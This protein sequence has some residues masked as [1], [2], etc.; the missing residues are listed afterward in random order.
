[1]K[2]EFKWL[3]LVYAVAVTL[4]VTLVFIPC[5][6]GDVKPGFYL[7]LF[8][9]FFY[10]AI[11]SIIIVAIIRTKWFEMPFGKC[12]ECSAF[13]CSSFTVGILALP[14]ALCRSPREDPHIDLLSAI[15]SFFGH[16]IL[17]NTTGFFFYRLY[18]VK[19]NNSWWIWMS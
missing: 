5:I 11:L 2:N 14:I 19:Q 16:F 13:W 18:V 15:L 17:I 3:T 4:A 9:F 6:L 1:M 8:C 10:I 7:L 12:L